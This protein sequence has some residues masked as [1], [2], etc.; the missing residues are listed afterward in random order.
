MHP[1]LVLLLALIISII[2]SYI[3][4]SQGVPIVQT[5]SGRL[6]GIA[7]SDTT[8]AYLGIPF[9]IPPVGE[10]RFLVPSPLLTPHITRNVTSL[11]P[12]C[13]QLQ[14][15]NYIETE[16]EDCLTLNIWTSRATP[17]T[18]A[19]SGKPVLI[20]IYGGGWNLSS[21]SWKRMCLC[22]RRMLYL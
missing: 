21:S 7:V 5:T 14:T 18:M 22:L 1:I 3:Y 8:N 15:T 13:I 17:S 20:W 4:R 6:R 12:A 10:L 11:G 2:S 9:A 16:S 19:Q